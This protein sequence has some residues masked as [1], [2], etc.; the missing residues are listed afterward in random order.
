MFDLEPAVAD[1]RRQMLAA[2]IKSPASLDELESHLREDIGK[3]RSSGTAEDQAFKIAVSRMGRPALLRTEFDQLKRAPCRAV[4]FGSWLWVGSVI[5]TVLFLSRG[6]FAGKLGLLL[7]AHIFSL[8]TGYAAAFLAG[9]L[10]IYYVWCR[11]GHA[12]RSA[13]QQS[14]GSAV[15]LFGELAAGLVVAGFVLGMFWSRRHLDDFLPGGAREIGTLCAAV[16]LVVFVVIQRAGLVSERAGMLLCIGGNVVISLAWFGA[17]I[18]ASRPEMRLR[19]AGMITVWLLAV[20]LIIQFA[21]IAK[22][23]GPVC[24]SEIAE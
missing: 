16:W 20:F 13:R 4:I 15:R 6:L 7:S 10:G 23:L 11:S 18:M 9:G 24:S 3:L 12:L 14:L 2:G 22:G 19:G 17:D 5:A 21:F 1:W 8:T